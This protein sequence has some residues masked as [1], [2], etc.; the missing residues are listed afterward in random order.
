MAKKEIQTS[1]DLQNLFLIHRDRQC[2]SS[3]PIHRHPF[4]ELILFEDGEGIHTVNGIDYDF[5]SHD[6]ALLAPSDIH[7]TCPTEGTTFNC[8]KVGFPHSIYGSNLKDLCR[9]DRFPIIVSLNSMDYTKANIL[10]GLLEEESNATDL[11][12]HDIFSINLVEQLFV[13]IVRNLDT[14]TVSNL[15]VKIT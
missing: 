8:T 15:P 2:S 12:G 3:G 14:K 5:K 7:Q 13:L 10:L 1:N 11:P 9:F 4:W 6:L